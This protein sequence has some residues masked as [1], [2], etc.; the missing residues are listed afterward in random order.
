M[1][2]LTLILIKSKALVLYK[3]YFWHICAFFVDVCF[4]SNILDTLEV[5]CK[6]TPNF[7]NLSKGCLC[8]Y[9]YIISHL[10]GGF[11]RYLDQTCRRRCLFSVSDQRRIGV[12][13]ACMVTGLQMLRSLVYF[14]VYL[15]L[16]EFQRFADALADEFGDMGVK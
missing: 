15:I 13:R 6:R 4:Y 11:F 14:P 12:L 3:C 2:H 8:L 16:R 7:Q 5:Y 9:I 10:F 1:W